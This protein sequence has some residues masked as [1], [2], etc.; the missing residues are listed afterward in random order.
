VEDFSAVI[1]ESKGGAL[2]EGAE[3]QRETKRGATEVSRLILRLRRW[4]D[5]WAVRWWW[6]C[7]AVATA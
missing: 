4:W 1:R 5:R 6:F 2:D 7:T 3:Q